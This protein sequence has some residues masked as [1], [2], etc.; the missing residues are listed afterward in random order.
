[1]R[2]SDERANHRSPLPDRL[3][4][5][6]G[7]HRSDARGRWIPLVALCH[8]ISHVAVPSRRPLISLTVVPTLPVADR[9]TDKDLTPIAA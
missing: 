3:G 7:A 6:P 5:G 9:S 1:M 4:Q 8:G 2:L